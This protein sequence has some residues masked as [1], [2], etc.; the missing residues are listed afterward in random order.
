MPKKNEKAERRK[1]DHLRKFIDKAPS[2]KKDELGRI[3]RRGELNKMK[4]DP[5]KGKTH[6]NVPSDPEELEEKAKR[7]SYYFTAA[8]DL[9]PHIKNMH[10]D[11]F[12]LSLSDDTLKA[13]EHEGI[14]TVEDFTMK[15]ES[16]L[17][18]LYGLTEEI[19]KETRDLLFSYGFRT[20]DNPPPKSE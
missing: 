16:T 14:E 2:S 1:L 10:F 11:S 5:E 15:S 18:R 17:L 12:R 8:A 13:L 20:V 6:P 19:Y 7:S 3:A 4:E 9:P